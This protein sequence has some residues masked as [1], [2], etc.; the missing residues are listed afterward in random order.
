[1]HFG[2]LISS[3]FF[4]LDDACAY[5]RHSFSE[6]KYRVWS[7]LAFGEKLGCFEK[8][9]STKNPNSDIDCPDITPLLFSGNQANR[10]AMKMESRLI[11][12]DTGSSLTK[13]CLGMPSN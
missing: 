6:P 8:P 2:H 7:Q 12:P 5:V 9:S 4:C 11:H 10:E 3:T 1:M 13:Y